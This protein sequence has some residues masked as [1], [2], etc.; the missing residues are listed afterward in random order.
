MNKNIILTILCSLSLTF[1][2]LGA[3]KHSKKKANKLSVKK[4][5]KKDREKITKKNSQILG[6][7][8]D[9]LKNKIFSFTASCNNNKE[10]EKTL[11]NFE[12]ASKDFQK[13]VKQFR[14]IF[15]PLNLKNQK[16]TQHALAFW[17]KA[18][19]QARNS[20][21]RNKDISTKDITIENYQDFIIA[22]NLATQ[23]CYKENNKQNQQAK[24]IIKNIIFSFIEKENNNKIIKDILKLASHLGETTLIEN[25]F[26]TNKALITVEIL[27]LMIDTAIENK[28]R[29]VLDTIESF[30]DHH[31]D[32]TKIKKELCTIAD[33]CLTE[34]MQGIDPSVIPFIINN[35]D[36]FIFKSYYDEDIYQEFSNPID[37]IVLHAFTW[38]TKERELFKL[39][40]KTYSKKI[41]SAQ[42]LERLIM[43][44]KSYDG[45][46]YGPCVSFDTIFNFAPQLLSKEYFTP[47]LFKKGINQILRRIMINEGPDNQKHLPLFKSHYGKDFITLIHNLFSNENEIWAQAKPNKKFTFLNNLISSESLKKLQDQEIEAIIL[48]K[49]KLNKN[50]LSSQSINSMLKQATKNEYVEIVT[51]LGKHPLVTLSNLKRILKIAIKKNVEVKMIIEDIIVAFIKKKNNIKIAKNML[52]TVIRLGESTLVTKI[53]KINL[54]PTEH[55]PLIINTAIKYK[56]QNVLDAIE[57]FIDQHENSAKIRR[58]ICS[59]ANDYFA[60]FIETTEPSVIPF[61]INNQNFFLFK[62]FYDESLFKELSNPVDKIILHAFDWMGEDNKKQLF[63]ILIQECGKKIFSRQLLK[64]LMA[65]AQN[66]KP[67]ISR[68]V[69]FDLAPEL[70]PKKYLTAKRF[71]KGLNKILAKTGAEKDTVIQ[72]DFTRLINS[73]KK[74]F[75][76]K[77]SLATLLQDFLSDKNKA[78]AHATI[79][80]KIIFLDLLGTNKVFKKLRNKE[81]DTIIKNA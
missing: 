67:L 15:L 50:G 42:L 9:V 11:Q 38:T 68:D 24:T 63:K 53:L 13:I 76:K 17:F 20:S 47:N 78:W 80:K 74:R 51:F 31:K 33:K 70:L 23:A 69:I 73:Y 6:P 45:E 77:L 32:G 61:I 81:I 14:N 30:I 58:V 4:E 40:I 66:D 49:I 34:F 57:S 39:L 72:N 28:H 2:F 48:N 12:L 79:S 41:F 75:R 44:W 55:F 18:I 21:N 64:L 1:A 3:K 35:R 26:K 43:P 7:L 46:E 52:D 56:H 54:T 25:I 19:E 65:S 10:L 8:Q 16:I 62:N 5:E 36:F 37:K 29:N 22:L 71:K 60:G 59:I 27:D